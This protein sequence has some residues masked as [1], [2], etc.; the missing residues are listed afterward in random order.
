MD[1]MGNNPDLFILRAM[2]DDNTELASET[3]WIGSFKYDQYRWLAAG[4]YI[5]KWLKDKRCMEVEYTPIRVC[6]CHEGTYEPEWEKGIF[7]DD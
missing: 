5:E 4:R 6:T 2:E 3:F 7:V 1:N